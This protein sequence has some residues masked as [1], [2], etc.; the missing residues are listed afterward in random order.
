MLFTDELELIIELY[1]HNN[2]QLAKELKAALFSRLKDICDNFTETREGIV[3]LKNDIKRIDNAWRFIYKRHT[4]PSVFSEDEVKTTIYKASP[5]L[6]K[7]IFN[8]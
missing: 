8:N 3:K 5:K 7:L 2:M 6:S 1:K 4:I